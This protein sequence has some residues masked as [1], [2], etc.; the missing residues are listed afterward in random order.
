M[1]AHLAVGLILPMFFFPPLAVLGFYALRVSAIGC[2]LFAVLAPGHYPAAAVCL[3]GSQRD[4]GD[5]WLRQLACTAN[6]R[7]GFFGRVLCSGLDQQIEH[8]LFPTLSHLQLPR[9]RPLVRAFCARTGLPYNELSWARAI[10]ESY[11]V[12]LKPKPVL[13]DVESLRRASELVS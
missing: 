12:F 10:W 6:F 2:V 7:T 1:L 4:A 8:H 9:A 11:R 5:F 3:D 13:A